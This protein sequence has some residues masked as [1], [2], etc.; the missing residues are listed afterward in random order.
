MQQ[1]RVA[2]AQ[3]VKTGRLLDAQRK[4]ECCV[5]IGESDLQVARKTVKI[6]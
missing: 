1:C 2:L 6:V 4:L 3:V 5:W